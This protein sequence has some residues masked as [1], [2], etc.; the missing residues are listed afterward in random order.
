MSNPIIFD[1]VWWLFDNSEGETCYYPAEAYGDDG[2]TMTSEITDL[3]PPRF[4]IV[5][6]T[7]DTLDAF[8]YQDKDE[9]WHVFGTRFEA[10]VA[11]LAPEGFRHHMTLLRNEVSCQDGSEPSIYLRRHTGAVLVYIRSDDHE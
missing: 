10:E 1:G 11:S 9:T 3:C 4:D 5:Q 2:S 8:G 7:I 6:G